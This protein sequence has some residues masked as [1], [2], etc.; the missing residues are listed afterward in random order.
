MSQSVCSTSKPVRIFGLRRKAPGIF[1][2]E[3]LHRLYV[4][5]HRDFVEMADI[6]VEGGVERESLVIS[7]RF[8]ALVTHHDLVMCH[9]SSHQIAFHCNFGVCP[10]GCD[11]QK[12]RKG[13]VGPL[14]KSPGHPQQ[15]E[16]LPPCPVSFGAAQSKKC[17]FCLFFSFS[18]RTKKWSLMKKKANCMDRLCRKCDSPSLCNNSH[19]IS[20]LLEKSANEFRMFLSP[21]CKRD[22]KTLLR[23]TFGFVASRQTLNEG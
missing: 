18:H 12:L 13:S 5:Y 1:N 15:T 22:I 2:P 16:E 11:H 6:S 14:Y 8:I 4:F 20:L 10:Y 21:P 23:N 19:F 17:P 9:Q 3:E 7:M